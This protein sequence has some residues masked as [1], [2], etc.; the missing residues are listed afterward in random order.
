WIISRQSFEIL[1]NSQE[2]PFPFP[3]HHPKHSSLS[4]GNKDRGWH[5]QQYL[6]DPLPER[7]WY[8]NKIMG[9]Q[10]DV[11]AQIASIQRAVEIHR[12][13]KRVS[14]L[15]TANHFHLFS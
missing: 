8:K 7:S 11:L 3:Q 4:F 5:Q 6:S 2:F 10:P 14:I 15:I 9:Q 13:Y 1:Y 12:N